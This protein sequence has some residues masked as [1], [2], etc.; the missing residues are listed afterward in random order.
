[1]STALQSVTR[2]TCRPVIFVWTHVAQRGG[3]WRRVL[4][5]PRVTAAH[6]GPVRTMWGP[7]LP[8]RKPF[9][10]LSAGPRRAT[11]DHSP[12][13]GPKWH[14][15]APPWPNT[16]LLTSP[17]R[18]LPFRDFAPFFRRIFCCLCSPRVIALQDVSWTCPSYPSAPFI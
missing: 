17:C 5:I 8:F 15:C 14:N 11:A 16:G 2:S 7:L 12:E 4:R 13:N 6:Q 10:G 9:C 1:M 18:P 3:I